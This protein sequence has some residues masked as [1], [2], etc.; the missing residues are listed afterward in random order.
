MARPAVV[1]ALPENESVPV[2][3]ELL[4]AGFEVIEV[5][6][7]D[8]LESALDARRDVAVAILEEAIETHPEIGKLPSTPTIRELLQRELRALGPQGSPSSDGPGGTI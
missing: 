4:A 8:Q 5:E 3:T 6:R 2:C 7:P 1:V